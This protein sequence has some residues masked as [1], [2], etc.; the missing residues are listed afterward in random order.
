[1]PNY[2]TPNNPEGGWFSYGLYPGGTSGPP[3]EAYS[4]VTNPERFAPLHEF[5]DALLNR[6]EAEFAV[7]RV[8]DYGLDPE[9]KT[10][11]LARPS[12]RLTPEDADAAP[13]LFKFTTFPSLMVRCGRWY[14][15]PF[16][17]CGC[18]ACDETAEVAA[19]QLELLVDDVTAGRFRE[20]IVLPTVGDAWHS[21][22][23]WSPDGR[24]SR[25]EGRLDRAR[26]QK[27]LAG[28]DRSLYEWKPWPVR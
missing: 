15:E 5:A 26:A 17:D 12:V 28:N 16:P 6:L 21:R 20:E 3:D 7:E 2:M 18:D 13:V 10:L 14:T 24:R 8:E 27:L 25:S 23:F 11:E 19:E 1:M 9:L 22:K 4:R